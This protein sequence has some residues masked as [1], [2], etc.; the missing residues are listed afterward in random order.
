[1]SEAVKTEV[2]RSA[3]TIKEGG[4]EIR[5]APEPEPEAPEETAEEKAEPDPPPPPQEFNLTEMEMLRLENI[6]MKRSALQREMA[7][8][9]DA[10]KKNKEAMEKRHNADDL[11]NYDINISTGIARRKKG[12]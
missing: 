10:A 7:H 4:G 1:M 12:A 2:T 5:K 6:T 3:P 8:L 11:A 9:A